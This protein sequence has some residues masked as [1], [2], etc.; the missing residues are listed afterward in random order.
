MVLYTVGRWVCG[1]L[2]SLY[3]G[4]LGLRTFAR[5]R[6]FSGKPSSY[7]DPG[8]QGSRPS[9]PLHGL[10]EL[11]KIPILIFSTS[12]PYV[13]H[14][15]AADRSAIAPHCRCEAGDLMVFFRRH[16]TDGELPPQKGV[17]HCVAATRFGRHHRRPSSQ[18]PTRCRPLIGFFVLQI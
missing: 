17:A 14:R 8:H 10:A 9:R 6:A 16:A 13:L 15:S 7:L 18:A 3:S 5:D 2:N 4:G 12:Y 11:F 1:Y